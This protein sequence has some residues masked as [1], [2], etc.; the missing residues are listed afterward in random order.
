M[1]T[2]LRGQ[3]TNV[4]YGAKYSFLPVHLDS[5]DHAIAVLSKGYWLPD[6]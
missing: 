5:G 4:D 2:Q 1:L 6:D 3:L